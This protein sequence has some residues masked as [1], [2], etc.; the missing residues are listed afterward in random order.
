VRHVDLKHV[1]R[2]GEEHCVV[3]SGA[4]Q[5]REQLCRTASIRTT[6]DIADEY[7][8]GRPNLAGSGELGGLTDVEI[9]KLLNPVADLK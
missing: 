6:E 4:V 2:R 1:K 3:T 8:S 9:D 7:D 5:G